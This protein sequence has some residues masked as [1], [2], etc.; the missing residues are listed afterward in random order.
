MQLKALRL[1]AMGLAGAVLLAAALPAPHAAAQAADDP[2]IASERETELVRIQRAVLDL[3]RHVGKDR[4]REVRNL[5]STYASRTSRDTLESQIAWIE[6]IESGDPRVMYETALRLRD[7]DGLPLHRDAAVTWLERAGDH[8]VP[9]GLFEASR[10]LL[11]NPL[12]EDDILRSDDF[13]RRAARKGVAEAQKV[14]GLQLASGGARPFRKDNEREFEIYRAR[15]W[16]LL[17]S[18][19]GA[20]VGDLYAVVGPLSPYRDQKVV[21]AIIERA[22]GRSLPTLWPIFEDDEAEGWREKRDIAMRWKECDR[23]LSILTSAAQTGDAG[24]DLELAR[25]YD[26]GTCVG[27]DAVKAHAHYEAA[28]NG[29]E[30]EAFLPAAL[31]YYDGRG[32]PKDLQ[33]ARHWFKAAALNLVDKSPSDDRRMIIARNGL[34]R[35]NGLRPR[36]FPAELAAEIIWLREIEDSEPQVLYETALRVRDGDGL[37]WV[38]DAAVALLR[39]AAKR[40]VMEANY[41]LGMLLL[42]APR[43]FLD[44][45]DGIRALALAG[46]NGFVPAQV[47]LGRRYASGNGVR[48]WDHTA[49]VWLLMADENG[50]D[51]AALLE[52]VGGRLTG[53]E[54]RAAREVAEKAASYPLR[55]R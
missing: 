43:G 37:P 55:S 18:A 17:A 25:S 49:Y 4:E 16:L 23:V 1:G 35:A 48:R 26:N 31:M 40:G 33:K 39:L 52:E 34:R 19:N 9:E 38:R 5:V 8:G 41:D 21:R 11:A 20:D 13:L 3:V 46:D 30:V 14:L 54:R 24:A 45:A 50:A 22:A 51:V 28:A 27:A 29:G 2:A 44:A 47:E 15:M 12:R 32:A 36:L 42:D 53:R 10:M 7:G 6:E